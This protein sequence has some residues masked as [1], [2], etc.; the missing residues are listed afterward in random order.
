MR[1]SRGFRPTTTQLGT[2]R[3]NKTFN[4][5]LNI[6]I[7]II[8]YFLG[9]L[10]GINKSITPKVNCNQYLSDMLGHGGRGSAMSPV[11]LEME[12]IIESSVEERVAKGK[13]LTF[14]QI[15]FVTTIS[16]YLFIIY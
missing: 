14:L 1:N 2:G 11:V 4:T 13:N 5:L 16:V 10:T 3:S 8:C 12:N 7:V 9:Y 6:V 15:F